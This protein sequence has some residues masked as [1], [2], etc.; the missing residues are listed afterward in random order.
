MRFVLV[1]GG[2]HGAWC[3]EKVVPEVE[4]LGHS[5]VAIDL[6][7][8]GGRADEVA[9]HASWRDA[10]REVIEDGD[11]L[12]GHSMGGFAISLGAD[13][14]PAK[15]SHLIYLAA[16][17]PSSGDSIQVS[18]QRWPALVGLP[19]EEFMEDVDLPKVGRCRRFTKQS[20]ANT[21]FYGDCAPADQ[22]WAWDRLGA[23]PL[24]ITED[25]LDL[26]RLAAATIPRHYI[27]LTNDQAMSL[28]HMATALTRLGVPFGYSLA[29]SHSPFL[30]R[31]SETAAVFA[32]CVRD[33]G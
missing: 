10:L 32:A 1:H 4:A 3:W 33:G 5:A 21:I 28:S 17:V 6:P 2:Y 12:V 25:R 9:T 22:D 24:S 19:L 14:V 27:V 30:S 8:L 31:P 18:G 15:I 16:A 23:Q 13:E 7:G 20:A 11:V 26:R 29:T